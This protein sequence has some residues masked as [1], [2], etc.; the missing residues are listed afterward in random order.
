MSAS[1]YNCTIRQSLSEILDFLCYLTV[2]L[3]KKF[4]IVRFTNWN[5]IKK[6][7]LIYRYW[8]EQKKPK[9]LAYKAKIKH[10]KLQQ[11]FFFTF[12]NRNKENENHI[13]FFLFKHE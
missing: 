11:N 5:L 3:N 2:L 13:R 12:S 6:L 10:K 7:T 4:Q 1:N 9:I 8:R